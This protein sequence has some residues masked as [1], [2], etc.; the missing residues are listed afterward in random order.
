MT[1]RI[2]DGKALAREVEAQAR[3]RLPP[4]RPSSRSRRRTG[5]RRPGKLRLCQ[6]QNPRLRTCRRHFNRIPPPGRYNG[7]GAARTD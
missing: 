3:A 5:G 7:K 4:G 6:K 1:A 2:I